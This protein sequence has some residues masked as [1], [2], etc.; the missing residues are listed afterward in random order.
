[1]KK[2]V[3]F[4]NNSKIPKTYSYF[5]TIRLFYNLLGYKESMKQNI[6]KYSKKI[7]DEDDLLKKIN[8]DF[9]YFLENKMFLEAGF[10]TI[11]F[12]RRIVE[13]LFSLKVD[14]F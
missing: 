3:I 11:N 7:W 8:Y 12:F 6:T 9:Y 5:F 14:D 13:K 1:M 4:N 10:I 2:Q